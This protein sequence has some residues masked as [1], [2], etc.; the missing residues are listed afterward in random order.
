MAPLLA[1]DDERTRRSEITTIEL[2]LALE[3]TLVILPIL[4]KVHSPRSM[5]L[6]CWW[7]HIMNFRAAQ[8]VAT[9]GFDRHANA[10]Q[11]PFNN[12]ERVPPSALT[13]R[14]VMIFYT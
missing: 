10:K 4:S 14:D 6:I 3:V 1:D 12:V 13:P 8:N 9:R 2:E 5:Q 7:G 11:L